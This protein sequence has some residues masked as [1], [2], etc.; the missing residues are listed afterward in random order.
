MNTPIASA[1]SMQIGRVDFY[2]VIV[3]VV[4]GRRNANGV[5][6]FVERMIVKIVRNARFL[7]CCSVLNVRVNI[8]SLILKHCQKQDL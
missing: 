1:E 5:Y 4:D 2:G 8:V 7:F 6:F 3:V